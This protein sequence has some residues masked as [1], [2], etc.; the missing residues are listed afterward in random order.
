MGGAR[1][2]GGMQWLWE[3]VVRGQ[4]FPCEWRSGEAEEEQGSTSVVTLRRGT[5][6]LEQMLGKRRPYS[7][8]LGNPNTP[9]SQDTP[10]PEHIVI[11]L[12][13]VLKTRICPFLFAHYFLRIA[14]I[15]TVRRPG[16]GV[17][18]PPWALL[19]LTLLRSSL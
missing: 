3:A 13:A 1:G 9:G 10:T 17:I 12:L 11:Q 6:V 5:P 19:C 4:A 16:L 2:D 8:V 15:P 14:A 7:G 18:N